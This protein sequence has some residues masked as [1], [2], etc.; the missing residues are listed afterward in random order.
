MEIKIQCPCGTKYKFEVEP[1]HG[2][3]PAPVN[4]PS[5]GAD[6]TSL[7]NDFLR[8]NLSAPTAPSSAPIPVAMAVPRAAFASPP[9]VSVAAAM[10]PPI[11]VAPA[12]AI[13]PVTFSGPGTGSIPNAPPIGYRTIGGSPPPPQFAPVTPAAPAPAQL[14]P[15]SP[16]SKSKNKLVTI[17]V[18]ALVVL[19][20]G[21]G[22]YRF[23][24]R[25]AKRFKAIADLATVISQ[26]SK[27]A[28][29]GE[30]QNL[31]YEDTV[32]LFIKHTNHLAVA[33]AC[34]AYWKDKLKKNLTVTESLDIA[35]QNGEY[36]VLS[37]HNGFVRL[38]GTRDWP[39]DQF[40]AVAKELSQKLDTLVFETSSEHVADT[41]HFGVYEQGTRKFHAQMD[42]KIT[43]DSAD[44]TVTTEGN[45]WAIA[46]GY[47]P[48]SD[49]FNSFDL[50]DADKI[51][52][53]LGLKLW[54][55]TEGAEVKGLL[56][57]ETA[58]K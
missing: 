11:P 20:V 12:A 17:L 33:D 39:P 1:V 36:S 31:T 19:C 44:E 21:F 7:A 54:D 8:T 16:S 30:P 49:G 3:M 2:R 32:V 55:E 57:T 41:Y 43:K 53:R 50:T 35:D 58:G 18:L 47:K 56:M 13:R 45:D 6:G 22:A 27:Q 42:V 5:C 29:K 24:S 25:W 40:E 15:S 38:M 48:G 46:N 34:K 37:A 4:C 51:T 10:P 23:G 28:A 26:A 14:A 52:Q 9:A